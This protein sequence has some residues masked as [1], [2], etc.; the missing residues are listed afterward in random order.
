VLPADDPSPAR[1][2]GEG[3]P[4]AL[5]GGAAAPHRRGDIELPPNVPP[6]AHHLGPPRRQ[7]PSRYGKPTAIGGGVTLGV[8]LFVAFLCFVLMLAGSSRGGGGRNGEEAPIVFILIG[9]G[10][11][12][13]GAFFLVRGLRGMTRKVLLCE[14]GFIDCRGSQIEVCP[15]DEAD[16]FW[17]Q[18]TDTRVY[19]NGVYQGTRRSHNFRLR[20]KDGRRF[21]WDDYYRDVGQLGPALEEQINRRRLPA[22]LADVQA[23]R[24]VDFGAIV[25]SPY[26]LELKRDHIPWGEVDSIELVQG[27]VHIRQPYRSDPWAKIPV[28]EVANVFIFLSVVQAVSG[29]VRM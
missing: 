19:M 18:V 25:V 9:L 3:N 14:R 13:A 22:A 16:A 12:G 24:A 26:G 11:A 1:G 20:M 6:E 29:K 23:G 7:F 4:F 17:R 28:H 21:D 10:V 2:G 27:Y 15:W 8:G 5:G